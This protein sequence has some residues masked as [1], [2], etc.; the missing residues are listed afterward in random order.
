M[1]EKPGIRLTSP[2]IHIGDLKVAPNWSCLGHELQLDQKDN[3]HS[4]IDYSFR[5]HHQI[6]ILG[7]YRDEPSQGIDE[8]NLRRVL[9]NIPVFHTTASSDSPFTVSHKV[10]MVFS[11]STSAMV[12][13]VST[14]ISTI[15]QLV[16]NVISWII[17]CLPYT[18]SSSCIFNNG[19]YSRS[20]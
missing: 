9:L 16:H 10:G 7:H 1:I 18:L 4:D 17:S 11:N 15:T 5:H 19:S 14:Q 12:N 8:W 3:T 6:G 20:Q 13:P 2:K